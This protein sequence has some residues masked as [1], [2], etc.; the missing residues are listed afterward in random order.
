MQHRSGWK[1][2]CEKYA[3]NTHR[4]SSK[5]ELCTRSKSSNKFSLVAATLCWSSFDV[6]FAG[7]RSNGALFNG[8]VGIVAC[9]VAHAPT[10]CRL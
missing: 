5:R 8:S 3:G 4:W 2:T 9:A 6:A 1:V 10:D 7:D